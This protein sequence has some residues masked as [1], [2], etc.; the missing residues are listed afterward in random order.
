M[1]SKELALTV[2]K[3]DARNFHQFDLAP[4]LLSSHGEGELT[5]AV[6]GG[7]DL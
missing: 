5:D 4:G 6:T 7:S 2:E 1:D 3:L